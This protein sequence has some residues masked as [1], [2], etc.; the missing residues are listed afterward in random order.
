MCI[1]I[2]ALRKARFST[3]GYATQYLWESQ[4][5]RQLNVWLN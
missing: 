5:A 2:Q 4:A 3:G 1:L